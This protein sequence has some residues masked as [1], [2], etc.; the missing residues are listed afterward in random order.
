MNRK[1]PFALT[2]A[3]LLV[4]TGCPPARAEEQKTFIRMKEVEIQGQI[5]HP[6]IT[7]IIPKTRIIF[8]PIP[9]E[10]DFSRE[11]RRTLTPAGIEEDIRL[12][13]LSWP[14]RQE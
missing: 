2:A 4:F 1:I 13:A 3:V 6:E 14:A 9:L 11:S 10:R 5:E 12:R 8:K 7:Y